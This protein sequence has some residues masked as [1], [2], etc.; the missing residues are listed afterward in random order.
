MGEDRRE[1]A[2]DR[3]ATLAQRGLDVVSFW[4]E[5]TDVVSHT[6][7]FDWYPCWFTVDPASLLI[8]SHFNEDVTELDP[9]VFQNEYV[10]DDF[11]KIADLAASSRPVSTLHG[12][13]GGS[14]DRSPRYRDLLTPFGIDQEL[15]GALRVEGQCW[16]AVALY[17]EPA[18]P[19]FETDDVRFVDQLAP[20]LAAGA[21]RGLLVAE[22]NAPQGP[23]SPGLV[24]V[25]GQGELES[26]TPGTER[27]LAE[28]PDGDMAAGRLP[29]SVLAVAGRARSAGGGDDEPA[30]LVFSRVLSGTGR[31]MVLHGASL[32]SGGTERAAV[33]IEPAQ[34]ARIAPLLM[35]A[36]GLTEREQEVS[37]LVFQG[38]STT[39]MAEHL[40]ISP[41]TVQTHLKNV[42]AKTGVRSRREL[43]AQVFFSFYEP[44]VRDNERRAMQREMLL[45][46]PLA[47]R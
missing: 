26:M 36:Y 3:I 27:W 34:P 18:R 15:I 21:R 25:D 31:W 42:F 29:S 22:A 8:T 9:A 17:R 47:E 4:R 2:V 35:E 10:E 19:T 39:E 5:C 41:H 16:A 23:D 1:R 28:L 38:Y 24:V 33:I 40:F 20:H 6:L 32:R 11:N 44:R 43:T 13:T 14:P 37:R 30:S 12:A 45:G 7:P 46:G